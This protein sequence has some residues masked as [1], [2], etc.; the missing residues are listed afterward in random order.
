VEHD[1]QCHE[2]TRDL[3]LLKDQLRTVADT[4]REVTDRAQDLVLQYH[5]QNVLQA[6][7][8]EQIAHM[9]AD[10]TVIKSTLETKVASREEHVTL[11]NQVW[12]GVGIIVSLF[13]AGLW[14]VITTAGV[15]K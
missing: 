7:M 9:Q 15:M 1:A 4:L 13:I 8:A 10:V 5:Q 3:A 11:R 6:R 14:R 12:W 2:Q